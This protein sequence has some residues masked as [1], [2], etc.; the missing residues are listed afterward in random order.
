MVIT[1]NPSINQHW[2]NLAHHNL[3]Q[4][5]KVHCK[6]T[7]RPVFFCD[8]KGTD[9]HDMLCTVRL[10]TNIYIYNC[11][12]SFVYSCYSGSLVSHK[13]M[14]KWICPISAAIFSP[15]QFCTSATVLLLMCDT[16]LFLNLVIIFWKAN[17]YMSLL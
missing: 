10:L 14:W 13:S 5:H 2:N 15:T 4:P 3:T 7:L 9:P 8:L 1:L 11:W 17:R 16:I 6:I 12:D